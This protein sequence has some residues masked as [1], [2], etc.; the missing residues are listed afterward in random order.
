MWRNVSSTTLE[1][2]AHTS[3]CRVT[4]LQVAPPPAMPR[5]GGYRDPTA[6]H[7]PVL[8]VPKSGIQLA[9]HTPGAALRMHSFDAFTCVETSVILSMSCEFRVY[10]L[11]LSMGGGT[12]S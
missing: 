10:S 9:L 2:T 4:A 8:S 5:F 7:G 12:Y 3:A 1:A 6:E 11:I